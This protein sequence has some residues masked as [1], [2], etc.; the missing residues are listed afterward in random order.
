MHTG[1]D[2]MARNRSVRNRRRP[3]RVLA[4]CLMAV[5]LCAP[6]SA[7][8]QEEDVE[9]AAGSVLYAAAGGLVGVVAGGYGNLAL[10]VLKARYG[11]YP[12]SFTDAFGWESIP[13][14]VGGA[15]GATVG[16]LD[17]ERLL[18]WIIGG[19]AGLVVGAGAGYLYGR[20]AWGDPESQWANAAI[21]AAVGMTLGSTL[22]LLRI[23]DGH[24]GGGP[25]GS[26]AALRV[27]L[28]QVSF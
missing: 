6:D 24:E 12:H 21:G 5:A 15:T 16:L 7:A 3:G 14:L 8:A 1:P 22:T 18:P 20:L 9:G 25:P 13:I 28:V 19:S 10:V 2:M 23:W 17:H 27:P 4:A 11:H 26:S